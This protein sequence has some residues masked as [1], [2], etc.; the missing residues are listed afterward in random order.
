M[1]EI[2][3]SE[4]W[5]IALKPY[6]KYELSKNSL[7]QVYDTTENF[8]KARRDIESLY[9]TARDDIKKSFMKNHEKLL[10]RHK[11]PACLYFAIANATLIKVLGGS[12][13]KDMVVNAGLAFHVSISAL[14]SFMVNGAD[15]EY[16]SYLETNGLQF[17]QSKNLDSNESYLVQT[18]KTLCHAQKRNKM[19]ILMLANIFFMLEAHTDSAYIST[20]R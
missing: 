8:S 17:P 2:K 9:N 16:K 15:S 18:I 5:D 4:F 20:K 11:V 6:I 19:D 7:Y 13:E 10:D 12:S 14:L 3:F 1:T